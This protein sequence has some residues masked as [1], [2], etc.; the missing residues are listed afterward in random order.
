[1]KKYRKGSAVV[2]AV[3]ITHSTFDAPHPNPEHVI[4]VI[5]D[6]RKRQVIFET[7]K[8]KPV[9]KLGDWIVRGAKGELCPVK[10]NVFRTSYEAV[11]RR[12]A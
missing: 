7:I 6:P 11:E 4:G 8:G 12:E 2:E 5:Y 1:M 10:D 3:Q 9:G